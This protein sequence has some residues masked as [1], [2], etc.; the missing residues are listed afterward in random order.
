MYAMGYTEPSGCS[1]LL[2]HKGS[3]KAVNK[4]VAVHVKGAGAVSDGIPV[5][6][7]KN[8][9]SGEL[10]A[11]CHHLFSRLDDRLGPYSL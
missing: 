10:A 4:G 6:E 9:W 3:T 11:A 5:G 7:E 8:R 2:L 1:C